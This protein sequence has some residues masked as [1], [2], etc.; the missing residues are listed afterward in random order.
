MSWTRKITSLSISTVGSYM[1]YCK[2][3]ELQ[4]NLI[5]EKKDISGSTSNRSQTFMSIINWRYN[6]ITFMA[7]WAIG[8]F[9]LFKQSLTLLKGDRWLSWIK[10]FLSG[11]FADD[12]R[13]C[14]PA[15][16]WMLVIQRYQK[17]TKKAK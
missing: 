3:I 12:I 6:L 13:F 8:L 16:S 5:L 4:L 1:I 15:Q 14:A 9:L 17:K 7:F 11:N 2:H 10:V